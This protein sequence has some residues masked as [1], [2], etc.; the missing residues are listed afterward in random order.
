MKIIRVVGMGLRSGS[1]GTARPVSG[2]EGASLPRRRVIH[3][4]PGNPV[5]TD[6]AL[7]SKGKADGTGETE[8]PLTARKSISI[9][10]D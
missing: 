7:C 10:A 3:R 8:A 2:G 4:L 5:L 1:E 9:S 6:A